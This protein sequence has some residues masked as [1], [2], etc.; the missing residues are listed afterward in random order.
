MDFQIYSQVFDNIHDIVL[1]VSRDGKIEYGNNAAVNFYGYDFEVLCGLSVFDIR[2]QDSKTRVIEQIN[3]AAESGIEFEAIHRKKD[4]TMRNV[5]VKSSFMVHKDSKTVI[6]IVHDMTE[7]RINAE[8]ASFFDAS[9][10]IAEEA[11]IATDT[12]FCINIWSKG[13][14]KRLGYC[15]EDV[16]GKKID[17][18]LPG[19]RIDEMNIIKEMLKI[20][21][22]INRIETSR[23]HK[24]GHIVDLSVEYAPMISIN[25]LI[26]GYIAVYSDITLQKMLKK[27]IV[28]YQQRAA[29]AIE[30]G[31]VY[32]MDLDI[33]RRSVFVNSMLELHL[34]YPR[35]TVT[36]SYD[37]WLRLIVEADYNRLASAYQQIHHNGDF[38]CEFRFKCA[39]GSSR[40]FNVKSRIDPYDMS[41]NSS[42]LIGVIENIDDTKRIE[43]ELKQK[44]NELKELSDAAQNANRVKNAFLANMSHEIRTPLNGIVTVTQLLEKSPLNDE[45]QKLLNMLGSSADSLRRI[46]N[47]ILDIS[48]AENNRVDIDRT[49]FSLRHLMDQLYN[50]MQQQANGKNIE[51][52]YYFDQQLDYDF[53]GDLGKLTQILEKLISNALKFTDSGYVSLRAKALSIDETDVLIEFSVKDTGIGIG[54][55]FK[56]QIFEIFSQ[57]DSSYEKSFGG[58]GLGLALSKQYAVAMGGDITFESIKGDA[59]DSGSTFY[60]KCRFTIATSALL[61]IDAASVHTPTSMYTYTYIPA[62]ALPQLPANTIAADGLEIEIFHSDIL[63]QSGKYDIGMYTSSIFEPR[64][65]L[66]VDDNLI[67]QNVMEYVIEGTGHKYLHAFDGEEALRLIE[68]EKIDL[69]LLDIQLPKMS[70]YELSRKLKGRSE[71]KHI[72][73]IAMTAYS[74]TEDMEKCIAAGMEAYIIKPID[75]NH[76]AELI[77]KHLL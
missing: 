43:L 10:D 63:E 58:T 30:S 33:I 2:V 4:G 32:V 57:E 9:L 44:N 62:M 77:N 5:L 49:R 16:I 22:R 65:I 31:K 11:I 36:S 64:T 34:G 70:G 18:M 8:K 37:S 1:I 41:G 13:A 12:E 14:E 67:N 45:Q 75:I 29:L 47:D 55:A 7:A 42:R 71:T 73:I 60:F 68:S 3:E 53:I 26:T 54:E 40:W 76:L 38:R 72:P 46:I 50:K 35:G 59:A 19:N 66:S 48:R 61:E 25:N 6:S 74:H 20:G 39:D 56:S 17:F 52:G 23:I 69:I 24:D 15:Y 27:E 51:A 28:E 21:K